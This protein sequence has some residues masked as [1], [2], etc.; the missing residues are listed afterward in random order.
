V[1]W[2][3]QQIMLGIILGML[4]LFGSIILGANLLFLHAHF[5]ST[6]MGTMIL[7]FLGII[8]STFTLIWAFITGGIADVFAGARMSGN[9][10]AILLRND[11]SV[12]FVPTKMKDGMG[13]T[14][15]YGKFIVIPDSVYNYENGTSGFIAYYKYGVSLHPNFVRATSR[16]R[17]SGVTDIEQVE[18]INGEAKSQNSSVE[19]KLD[20]RRK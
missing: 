20:A 7:M 9:P 14:K 11:K 19:V 8:V 16:L 3:R 1:V 4:G 10:V 6:Q 2:R 13:E 5:I 17:D 12:K 18:Y 15:R